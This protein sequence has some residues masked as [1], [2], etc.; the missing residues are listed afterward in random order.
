MLPVDRRAFLLGAGASGLAACAKPERDLLAPF[1]DVDIPL[2]PAPTNTLP[3]VSAVPDVVPGSPMQQLR[4]SVPFEDQAGLSFYARATG[5]EVA[6]ELRPNDPEPTWTFSNPIESGDDLVFLVDDFDGEDRYRVLLPVRPNGSYG[7]IRADDVELLRHNFRILI[8]LDAFRLTL[9]D[10]EAEAFST[11]VGVA[12]ENAPTPLGQYYTTEL[13]QPAVPDTLYGAYA[14]GLSGY[15]ETFTS[16]NGGPGQ[17]GIHGTSEPESIGT[18]VSAGCI[19][20]L[21]ADITRLVE[22]FRVAP[23]VPV[24]VI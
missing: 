6:V 9:F 8:E 18:N 4:A 16:F 19:R 10:R 13:I 15:S 7:W 12:R 24:E 22:E 21:D 5:S 17:L 2:E 14:Y 11:T 3:A 23:G 1:E 20:M